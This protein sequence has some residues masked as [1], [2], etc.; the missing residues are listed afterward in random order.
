MNR[1][2]S[3]NLPSSHKLWPDKLAPR[4]SQD[5]TDFPTFTYYL[6]SEEYRTGQ[7]VLILPGGGYHLV[8]TA[9]EGHRPAQFLC[10]RGIACAVLE[11]RHFPLLHP[12][13]LLDAQRGL[14]LLRSLAIANELN[15]GQTGVMGFSAGGHLAGLLATQPPH[16]EAAVGDE[17]DAVSSRPDFC[18]MIYGVVTLIESCANKGSPKGLLGEM[19]GSELLAA[20]SIERAV[21][22]GAPPFFLAHGQNDTVVPVENALLLYRACLE[23][24]ASA[25]M[26][27]YADFC[28]GIGMAKNHPWARDLGEWLESL[29]A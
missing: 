14:R 29:R 19:P 9:K 1:H 11:Y 6:P 13:P 24:N 5:E 22:E 4:P 23:K 16:P 26:H 10:A 21:P 8:S 15:P 2:P 28:H 17:L 18:A 25:T 27:L 7:S 12:V 3:I 20:L